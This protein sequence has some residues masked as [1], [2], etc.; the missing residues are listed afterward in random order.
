MDITYGISDLLQR[1]AA[2]DI[3]FMAKLPSDLEYEKVTTRV[4]ACL[5]SDEGCTGSAKGFF[6]PQSTVE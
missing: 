2:I 3:S 4:E 1:Y 5:K 6:T